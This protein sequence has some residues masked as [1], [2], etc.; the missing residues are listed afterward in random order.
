MSQNILLKVKLFSAFAHPVRLRILEELKKKERCVSELVGSIKNVSQSQVSN[1]L[2]CLRDCGLVSSRR[3]WRKVYYGL[4]DPKVEELLK[5][6][7]ELLP[8]VSERVGK[9]LELRKETRRCL[10]VK[11][12]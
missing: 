5:V 1:H 10:K 2:I 9:C 12:L 4:A 3:E 8:T 11:P 7:D 6:A